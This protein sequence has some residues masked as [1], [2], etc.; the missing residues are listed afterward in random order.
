MND[1]T[2]GRLG[3]LAAGLAAVLALAA[4]A[5]AQS[6]D[7]EV[8]CVLLSNAM[9]GGAD[10]PRGRQ[11][12]ASVGAYFM[13]RL[14]ARPPAQ[15]KAAIAGQKRKMKAAAAATAMNACVARAGRAE[16]RLRQLAQ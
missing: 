15:V 10:N 14:D 6:V 3:M 9:A 11:I 16:A 7:D 13:G 4:P 1:T 2:F 8:R 5:D 12:G